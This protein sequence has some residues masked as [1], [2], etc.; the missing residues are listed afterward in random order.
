[1]GPAEVTVVTLHAEK[2]ALQ[3]ELPGRTTASLSSEVRP[4]ITGHRQGAHVRGGRARQGGAGALPDRAGA[5]TAPRSPAPRPTSRRRRRRSRRRSSRTSA[6]RACRRSRACR[7][8]RPTTRALHARADGR[9]RGA[10]AGRARDRAH[11][12]RLHVDQRADQR[13]DQQVERHRRARSSPRTSP[14]R[15]RRSARSIRSTSISPSRTRQRLRLR[16]QLG[17]GTLQ[18]GIDHG[19]AHARRRLDVRARRHARVRRGRGR[20]GDR[21]G[22]AAREVPEP[23]RRRCCPA[24]TCARCSTRRSTRTRSSRRSRAS[25]TTPRATRPRWSSAPTARPSRA[26]SSRI[27][28]RRS[29]AGRR[30]ASHAGD[31]LIVEG[32]NKIGPGM[33][34][35][36]DETGGCAAGAGRDPGSAAR[37]ALTCSRRFFASRPGLRVGDLDRDH[38]RGRRVDPRAAGRAVPRRRAAERQHQRRLPRRVGR[39]R[40]EQRHPGARA[41]AHRH[42]RPAV[43]LELVE[44]VAGQASINV[45]FKQGTDPDTAQVQVQNKVQQAIPRLPPTVQQSGHRRHQGAD[46]LPDDRRD[47]RRVRQGDRAPTSPTTSA[48][49]SRIRSRASTASA[50]SR[51]SARSYAMRIWLDPTKLSALQP[52]AVGRRGRDRRAER[53]GLGG[54]DRPAAGA[55]GPAAQRDGHRAEQAAHRRGVPRHHRQVRR[56]R[57]DRAARRC[58][59]RRARQRVVRLRDRGSTATR[60]RASRS[61]SRR[62]R[63]RC[64]S[65]SDV[66]AVVNSLAAHDAAGLEGQLPVRLDEVHPASRSR[67]SSR[68]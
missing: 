21:H 30:A 20:R 11:Q 48:A 34:V 7:S 47:L 26:R 57:R 45:T 29:L 31:K 46:E 37:E 12:P 3:T 27:A 36:A 56:R 53:P 52:D 18:A 68:R 6:T 17:A 49:R 8:R 22:D 35:H 15:S 67:R 4:Q 51:S 60:R 2:V 1:M 63:T 13:T 55:A 54:Q 58:R 33:P 66:K 23:R 42:R 41:A 16:A 25:R 14:S 24:C 10:E 64:R 19:Q 39:D 5:C 32:T 28:H 61:C 40:R 59:A 9:D 65:P 50:R 43:L 62:T 38:A 44:L